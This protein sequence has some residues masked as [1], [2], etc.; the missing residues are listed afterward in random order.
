[1]E[2]FALKLILLIIKYL[3]VVWIIGVSRLQR[4]FFFFQILER[5]YS[6]KIDFYR[7]YFDRYNFSL[8]LSFLQDRGIN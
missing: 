7:I 5:F 8:F 4:F 6:M 2:N 3:Y 1:M